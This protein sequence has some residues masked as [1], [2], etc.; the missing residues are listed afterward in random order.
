MIVNKVVVPCQPNPVTWE[1]EGKSRRDQFIAGMLAGGGTTLL[2][3]PVDLLKVR[4]QLDPSASKRPTLFTLKELVRIGRQYKLEGLYQGF[5][6]NWLA[7]M[8]AWGLYFC[9]YDKFK[10][11]LRANDHTSLQSAK[12]F[13]ASGMAGMLTILLVNPLWV[14][15]TR[16]CSQLPSASNKYKGLFSTLRLITQEEGL[17]GL[18][19]GLLPGLLGVSH[20]AIQFTVYESLKNASKRHGIQLDNKLYLAMSVTS[21]T[22]AMLATYPYQVVRSRAQMP[23]VYGPSLLGIIRNT[24]AKEGVYGFYKGLVPSSMRVLPGT[25]ITF[26]IYE[27]VI[28]RLR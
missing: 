13:G 27:N 26:L 7:S 22:A 14:V 12:Y 6:A 24:W 4:F 8:S 9:L 3:H 15:K 11:I 17:P 5:S 19:R 20:G 1:M 2:M 25:A 18:Y 21:K 10:E 23:A 28:N 16:L